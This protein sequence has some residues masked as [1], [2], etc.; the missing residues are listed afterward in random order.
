MVK[1][2]KMPRIL[3]D[4]D[5]WGQQTNGGCHCVDNIRYALVEYKLNSETRTYDEA[6]E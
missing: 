5:R 3:E 2:G 1:I 6:S 4:E